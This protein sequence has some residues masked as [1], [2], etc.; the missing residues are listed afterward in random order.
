M[1]LKMLNQKRLKI[2][3]VRLFASPNVQLFA[4]QLPTAL[5]QQVHSD[6]IG[7]LAQ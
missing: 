4:S 7:A 5:R 2:A 3:Q 6:G 1:I